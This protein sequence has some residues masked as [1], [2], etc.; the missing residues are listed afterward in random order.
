MHKLRNGKATHYQIGVFLGCGA[1]SNQLFYLIES[2]DCYDHISCLAVISKKDLIENG[3]WF[4]SNC[5]AIQ[6][7]VYTEESSYCLEEFDALILPESNLSIYSFIPENIIKIGLPHGT[8]VAIHS[9]LFTYGGGFCFDYILCAIKQPTL[10]K[11]VYRNGFPKLFR[12][13]QSSSV[14]LVPFGSPKLDVFIHEVQTKDSSDKTAIVYHLSLLSIEEPWV[15]ARMPDVLKA[16]LSE[17]PDRRIIYRVHHLDKENPSV[18]QC[19]AMGIEYSNFYFSSDDSYVK[20]YALGTLMVVHREYA[21]HLFDLATGSPTLLVTKQISYKMQ[22]EHNER[23]FVA[24]LSTFVDS[25]KELLSKSFDRTM[26]C[27]ESNCNEI[28][29]YNPGNSIGAL[30][31]S[32]PQIIQG[33]RRTDWITYAFDNCNKGDID[34]KLTQFLLSKK[35]FGHYAFAY[36]HYAKKSPISL[37]L[38]A[39]HFVRY[40]FIEDYFYPHALNYF[41]QLIHHENFAEVEE[42]AQNWWVHN[43]KAALTFC[44]SLVDSGH[45]EITDEIAWLHNHYC[46]GSIIENDST[47]EESNLEFMHL[48]TREPLPSGEVLIVGVSKLTAQIIEKIGSR[49]NAVFDDNYVKEQSIYMGKPVYGLSEIT[50]YPQ[51]IVVASHKGLVAQVNRLTLTIAVKNEIYGALDEPLIKSMV[52]AVP[53]LQIEN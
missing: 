25:I 49:V 35:T 50:K 40:N 42:V 38:L 33:K 36:A 45:L 22:F 31:E 41:Y 53:K 21:S 18:H 9:T 24:D 11:D 44:L 46:E 48:R 34:S 14:T 2:L 27:I 37:L 10:D 5:A 32:L 19:I 16:L 30:V 23:Y 52:E 51:N 20:D 7:F 13:Q 3:N 43:G 8:D 4:N 15:E 29:I 39:E 28:G 12:T 6:K 1:T 17:F 26:T 47:N